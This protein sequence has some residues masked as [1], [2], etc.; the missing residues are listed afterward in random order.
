MIALVIILIMI[1]V[2]I[3]VTIYAAARI[4]GQISENERNKNE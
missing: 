2:F 4:S 1:M 3:L